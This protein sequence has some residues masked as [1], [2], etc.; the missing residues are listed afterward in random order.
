MKINAPRLKAVP[1]EKPPEL[2]RRQAR[3]EKTL[4]EYA[5]VLK[6]DADWDYNHIL[7]ILKYKMERVRNHIVGH[8]IIKGAKRIGR[9]MDEPIRLLG[10]VI[11]D[12]YD[13][14]TM[15]AF[16]AKHGQAKMIRESPDENGNV[17]IKFLYRNGKQAT[18]KMGREMRK[19]YERAHE[20]RKADLR[21]AFE[22]MVENLW[23]WWD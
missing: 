4:G 3:F 7:R 10:R 15:R 19:A 8:N 21:R 6:E 18:E 9:E 1:G 11:E 5:E 17:P 20:R 12:E 13:R 22:I 23:S 2:K 16:H 14:E